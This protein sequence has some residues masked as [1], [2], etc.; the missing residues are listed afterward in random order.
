MST[1]GPERVP[2]SVKVGKTSGQGKPPTGGASKKPPAKGPAGKGGGKG[3]KPVAPVKVATGSS[4]VSRKS[5]VRDASRAPDPVGVNTTVVPAP[6]HYASSVLGAAAI[7][8]DET[9]NA[10][11]PMRITRI[12]P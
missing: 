6:R 7:A 9:P 1:P 12:R 4:A 10:T 11:R 8:I 3:R 2:Q 5:Q